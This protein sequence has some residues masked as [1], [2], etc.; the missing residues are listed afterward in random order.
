MKR[1]P[2]AEPSVPRMIRDVRFSRSYQRMV[3]AVL[4]WAG[5]EHPGEM[6]VEVVAADRGG[7]RV[8]L[9]RIPVGIGEDELKS[10][11]ASLSEEAES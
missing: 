9:A 7:D 4:V 11:V 8:V 10:I 5:L 3:R 6:M 1:K 2:S